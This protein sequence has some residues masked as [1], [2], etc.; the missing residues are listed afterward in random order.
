M[1]YTHVQLCIQL[2]ASYIFVDAE[3]YKQLFI[4]ATGM[5]CH[6]HGTYIDKTAIICSVILCPQCYDILLISKVN[7]YTGFYITL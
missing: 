6:L 7:L 1:F 3:L 4:I 2:L 5:F